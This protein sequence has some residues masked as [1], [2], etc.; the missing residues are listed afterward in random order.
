MEESGEI[1]WLRLEYEEELLVV[2]ELLPGVLV[3]CLE[4]E[5]ILGGDFLVVQKT[6]N[7]TTEMFL[8]LYDFIKGDFILDE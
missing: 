1:V 7:V 3:Q 2:L 5:R 8:M 4:I 6:A